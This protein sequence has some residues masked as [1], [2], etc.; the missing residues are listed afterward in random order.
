MGFF[1]NLPTFQGGIASQPNR[2]NCR[3]QAM[4][5][6]N[7]I[8]IKGMR[9]LDIACYNARWTYASIHLGAKHVTAIEK[10]P[11]Y[12]NQAS[13]NME[14]MAVNPDRYEIICG[15]IHKEIKRFEPGDF[16][17]I[18][19]FGF[20]YH[21]PRHDYLVDKMVGLNPRA[22]IM[23]TQVA[24]PGHGI[25]FNNPPYYGRQGK[26]AYGVIQKMF[27]QRGYKIVKRSD[28]NQF[29]NTANIGDYIAG[30]NGGRVTMLVRPKR[31]INAQAA[32][33][34]QKPKSPNPAAE[35]AAARR[36]DAK[37]WK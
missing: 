13:R 37:K 16:D 31:E 23:D 19:C 35:R 36:R 10:N 34:P 26:A 1:D 18:L 12:A 9:V 2:L 4:M 21:T 29:K 7:K 5:A 27:G 11:Q 6:W 25:E 17:T 30:K 14:T 20:F 24:K 28:Y 33:N 22:I 3:Y 8:W 15:D 32:L